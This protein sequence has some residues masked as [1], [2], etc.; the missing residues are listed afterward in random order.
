M[1]DLFIMERLLRAVSPAAQLVL[2]G[3]ADQLPSVDT[4]AVLRDLIPEVVSTDAPWRSLVDEE[5][6]S[7]RGDAV[8]AGVAVRLETSYRMREEDPAG[9]QILSFARGIRDY[10]E[11]HAL[12]PM[13]Q[14]E[15]MDE[16]P[17]GVCHWSPSRDIFTNWW[18]ERVVLGGDPKKWRPRFNHTH[19]LDD[20]GRLSD[21]AA[22]RIKILLKHYDRAR[23]L[24]LTRVY[25]T[26]SEQLNEAFH[27][28]TARLGRDRLE[29]D[30]DF[31]PGEPVMMLR[32]DYD[33]NLFNG[34]QGV[35]VWCEQRR[36]GADKDLT[37]MAVFERTD[38]L[39]A[40]PLAELGD[41]LEHAFAMTVHKAQGSEFER[42]ALVLPEQPMPLLNRELLYTGLTRASRG[43]LL[44][45]QPDLV[46][47]GA[48]NRS[49]RFSAVGEK[50]ES[51]IRTTN[52]D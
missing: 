4:G 21:D 22:Q 27:R 23:M 34:D 10:D 15:E 36:D 41:D 42:V 1:I 31:H 37:L 11:R 32:N 52:P 6:E 13:E 30:F 50:L 20:D 8:T 7:R 26:G 38:S 2:L 40:Y 14:V 3:D 16:F 35:V 17:D 29:G 44:V 25:S 5:L 28:E 9:R 24:T 49:E 47:V 43:V 46:E 33:R 18:F 12:D 19:Q 39:I 45:G 51:S 48:A